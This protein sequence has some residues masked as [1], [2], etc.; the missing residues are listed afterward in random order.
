MRRGI[1]LVLDVL[2]ILCAASPRLLQ[3]TESGGGGGGSGLDLDPDLDRSLLLLLVLDVASMR[4]GM[5]DVLDNDDDA[6]RHP[7]W[8]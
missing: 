7:S 4:R 3:P 8:S 6:M 5:L 1:L 2:G